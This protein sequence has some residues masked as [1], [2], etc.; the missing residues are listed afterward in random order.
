MDRPVSALAVWALGVT[1]IIGYGTLYYAFTILTPAIGHTYGWS[2]DLA[3]AALSAALLV[4]G[5]LSPLAGRLLDRFG[6]A[7]VMALGSML[8]AATLAASAIAADG[9]LFV[10]VLVAMQVASTAIL[11]A[12]AFAA[13]VEL[14]GRSAQKSITHLTLIAGFAS[15]IFWPFTGVLAEAFNWQQIFLI[16][17]A[18]HIVVCAP[19]HLWLAAHSGQR[20]MA[21]R[22]ENGS[23]QTEIRPALPSELQRYA[24]MLLLF[25]FAVEGF[26]LSGVLLHVVP[27]LEALGLAAIS[28]L[29]TSLFGPSQVLSRVV[30]MLFGKGLRQTHL[31][32]IAAALLP[33]GLIALAATAPSPLGAL[34]FAI[35]FGLG[36]GLTSIVAG[37]LPLELFGTQRYGTR[38]GSL[39]S[40]RQIAAAVAPF[41][42][43]SLVT[44]SGTAMAAWI[45][46]GLGCLG[47]G[48]FW[49]VAVIADRAS[50]VTAEV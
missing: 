32:I 16:F 48:S 12:A 22:A 34:V 6:A 49:L 1:Q 40:A 7:R 5:F 50:A 15:T 2:T 10:I 25:G 30:N 37:S 24:S 35:L 31:A 33:S 44:V 19:L 9:V 3:F 20:R 23:R 36:S 21:Q 11:Y 8:A 13:L 39:S 18:L 17:A 27:M 46:A 41:A 42:V 38:L 28:L 43:A 45:I 4:S 29:V 26:I 14:G 47:V